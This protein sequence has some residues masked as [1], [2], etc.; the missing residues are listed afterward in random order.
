MT[1]T[2]VSAAAEARDKQAQE[3]RRLYDA[4]A[5]V[6]DLEHVSQLSHGTVV[7]RLRR[8][9]TVMR[10]PA[11]TRRLRT[12]RS[13]V[14]RQLQG[15][16]LREQY[17]RDGMSVQALA[18]QEGLSARTVRRRLRA[19]GA[20][21]R[22][23]AQARR[24]AADPVAAEARRRLAADLRKR[25]EDGTGVTALAAEYGRSVSTVYRLL[26]EAGA[27]RPRSR[28]ASQKPSQPP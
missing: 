15:R 17:E 4:G 26:H 13:E 21:L 6:E 25:Y 10:T 22:S 2:S 24:L 8:A 5:T 7:N 12:G 14:L 27:L 1:A 20:V 23:G 18:V 28:T 19:A 9:G 3:L 11:E 16:R